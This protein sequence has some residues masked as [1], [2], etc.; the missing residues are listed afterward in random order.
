M[1]GQKN[2]KTPFTVMIAS[3][4]LWWRTVCKNLCWFLNIFVPEGSHL[5]MKIAT[6]FAQA[7]MLTMFPLFT[8]HGLTFHS[9]VHFSSDSQ[10]YQHCIW[11]WTQH[12]IKFP[13]VCPSKEIVQK[14][15]VYLNHCS[16][17][18][19]GIFLSMSLLSGCVLGSQWT[20]RI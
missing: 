10:T 16:Q 19:N 4:H 14:L 1:H 12:Y 13:K 11:A 5:W 8:T 20:N 3:D 17:T 2:I 9:S 7:L 15:L 18:M 6:T